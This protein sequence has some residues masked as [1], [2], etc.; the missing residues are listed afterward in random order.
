MSTEEN[1]IHRVFFHEVGHFIANEINYS[2]YR[3]RGNNGLTIYPCE[4][5]CDKMCGE[6]IRHSL[7]SGRKLDIALELSSLFYG[8]LLEN[9]LYGTEIDAC[10]SHRG[11]GCHDAND[12]AGLLSGMKL[13][14]FSRIENEFLHKV[15]QKKPFEVLRQLIPSEYFSNAEE[16]TQAGNFRYVVDIHKLKRSIKGLV[17][18]HFELYAELVDAYKNELS[19]YEEPDY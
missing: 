13:A 11:N 3:Y 14:D 17:D 15:E 5:N 19:K 6:T 4:G 8:C 18:S 1:E 7:E 10:L 9:Y 12:R 16:I 2:K